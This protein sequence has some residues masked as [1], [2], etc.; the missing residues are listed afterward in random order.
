MNALEIVKTRKSVRTFDGTGLTDEDLERIKKEMVNTSNPFGVD[1]SFVLL[2]GEKE[3]LSSPVLAGERYFVA[4]KVKKVENAEVAY[5]YA[6]EQFVLSAWNMGIG[7]VW[8]GG[9]MKREAFEKAAML[10]ADEMM[11]CMTPIGYPAKKRS[12]K[13]TMMRKGVGA[14]KRMP[15]SELFFM[16]ERNTKINLA[17]E[18]VRWAPSA[19]NKQP[20]RIVQKENKY[21]FYEKQDKGYVS[22][23][24]GDLQKIDIGIAMRHFTLAFDNFAIEIEDPRLDYEWNYV[25]S[26]VVNE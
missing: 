3:K 10:G 13:E 5:G 24:T 25:A 20:W 4:G 22:D 21:H 8:I 26:V 2:D 12:V 15:D 7:T 19:V 23:K 9:T 11:P 6:F 16:E 14:D 1:V 18:L 17:L